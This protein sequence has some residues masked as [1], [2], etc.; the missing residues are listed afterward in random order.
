MIQS[1]PST[2]AYR[3]G[4]D[5]IFAKTFSRRDRH[6]ERVFD[7]KA[8][9]QFMADYKAIASGRH[10]PPPQETEWTINESR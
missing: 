3:S 5:R 6:G 10:R 2:D 9:D 4:W 7:K 1:R 8:W